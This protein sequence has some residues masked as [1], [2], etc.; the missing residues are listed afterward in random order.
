MFADWGLAIAVAVGLLA[1]ATL[2]DRM[3]SPTGTAPD[4]Q[5]DDVAGGEV[6]LA[7]LRGS[8]V[9]LN[10]WGSWCPPCRSEIPELSA[11][12][13]AHPETKLLGIAVR[14]GRGDE[15]RRAAVA[16]GTRYPV[17]VADDATVAAYGVD[18][19]PTTIVV[20]EDGSIGAV[21]RGTLD[22]D[23]LQRLVEKA[24]GS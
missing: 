20:R 7:D 1:A 18:V 12:A 11:W 24:K 13:E 8:V 14:S 6:H 3:R 19:F 17:L 5:L 4:F 2:F 16:L 15:L 23:D 21:R 9:V 10:F 22:A